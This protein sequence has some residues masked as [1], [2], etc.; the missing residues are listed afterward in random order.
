MSTKIPATV[1]TGFLGAGKTSLIRHLLRKRQWPPARADHQ[2]VRRYRRRRRAA[3]RLR[4]SRPA[5]RRTSSSSP[6]A[7]SAAPLPMIS[8]RP[9]RSCSTADPARPY[10]DRDLRPGAAASR[11]SRPS[12][13]R[14]CAPASPSTASSPWS[15]P[16]PSRRA[17]SPDDPEAVRAARRADD[18]AR[19]RQPDGGAVRGAAPLRRYGRAQQGRP[20]GCRRAGPRS[21]R[22]WREHL[23]PA[24]KVVSAVRVASMR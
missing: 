17:A 1:I 10:R 9:S 24:V 7:A 16:R 15:M 12:P 22:S 13:G 18:L 11:W 4:R 20:D 2:R 6:T 21:R 19:S 3:R 8:C 14:R 5:A 23:R